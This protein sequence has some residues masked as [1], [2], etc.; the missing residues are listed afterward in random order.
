MKKI[1]LL[2]VFLIF[3]SGMLTAQELRCNVTISSQKIKRVPNHA[4]VPDRDIAS[5]IFKYL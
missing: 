1:S 5:G 3:V 4:F 2:I